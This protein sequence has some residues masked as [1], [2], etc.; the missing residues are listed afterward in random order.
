MDLVVIIIIIK[1]RTKDK[2]QITVFLHYTRV[3]SVERG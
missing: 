2:I 1:K 3:T